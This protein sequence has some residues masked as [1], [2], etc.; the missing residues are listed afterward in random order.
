MKLFREAPPG[1]RTRHVV[2][3][4]VQT[5]GFW[6]VF[7]LVIPAG[8]W[9]AENA[10][11]IA[12]F[13]FR[14]RGLVAALAFA[15]AS[16]G[17][18]W[19]GFTMAL[20]GDG[21]PLPLTCARRLVVVGPYRVVRNPMAIAGLAQGAAVGIGL[22]SWSV[23]AYVGAG[24]WLWNYTARPLEE[25]DLRA[26]FGADYARYCEEVRCWVPTLRSVRQLVIRLLFRPT[27]LYNQIMHRLRPARRWWDRVDEHVI[28]GALPLPHHVD[29][30]AREGVRA[31]VNTC[32]EYAGPEREYARAGIE[33]LRVPCLDFTPPSGDDVERAVA[34]IDQHARRGETV[35]VH[36][37]AGRGR[38][39]TIALCWL[40]HA[41]G[42]TPEAAQQRLQAVR[43]H[44]NR[45]LW[46]RQVVQQFAARGA[47][48]VAR[49]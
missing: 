31:V 12:H 25:R 18:L 17:G 46:Q 27:L 49:A 28:V 10:L 34:F 44:V 4:L 14:G 32:L 5:V 43:P 2:R 45:G 15:V 41:H 26:R 24:V 3:T 30:L 16:A 29:G 6:L 20:H 37:K 23:L 22:G 7:L 19:S 48:R 13:T 47:H 9:W 33:Q 42:M 39:A 38:S 8:I 36:C 40:V 1:T 21:T 11:G 35:Y